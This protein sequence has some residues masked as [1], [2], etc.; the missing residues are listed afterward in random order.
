M[1]AGFRT[2]K[3]VLGTVQFGLNYGISNTKGQVPLEEVCRIVDYAYNH[4]V[5]T[6]DT[7][8]AYGESEIILGKALKETGLKFNIISKLP[9]VQS[10]GEVRKIVEASLYKLGVSTLQGYML[11]S[12]SIYQQHPE[13]LEQLYLLEEEGLISNIGFSL[14]H[15]SEAQ[16]LLEKNINFNLTQFPYSVFDQRF[17]EVMP[18]L[19]TKGIE[20]HV[21]S[22]FL[23]GL[24]FMQ[25]YSLPPYF[26]GVAD[27]LRSLQNKAIKAAIPLEAVLMHFVLNQPNIDKIVIGVDSLTAL[28]ENLS[29]NQYASQVQSLIPE[30]KKYKVADENILLPYKWNIA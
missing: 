2:E 24:F 8:A 7:A 13:V 17:D 3:I 14:Y 16:E 19:K 22:V 27:S 23:Q 29:I 1:A 11:H 25:P 12:F 26:A 21:R 10:A 18:A 30:L 15:P 6:L 4:G 20:T 5:T 9:L 28:Q